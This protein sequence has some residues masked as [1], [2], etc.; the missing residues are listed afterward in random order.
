MTTLTS[1]PGGRPGRRAWAPNPPTYLGTMLAGWAGGETLSSSPRGMQFSNLHR[2]A[3]DIV[4]ADMLQPQVVLCA[5][6]NP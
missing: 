1:F 2:Q 5:G 3:G 4:P 6:R